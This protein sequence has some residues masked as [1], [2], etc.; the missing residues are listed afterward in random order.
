[1]FC[2]SS[3]A[4]TT[5]LSAGYEATSCRAGDRERVELL[6]PG[7]RDLR[8]CSRALVADDVVVELAR[9]E[10]E[11]PHARRA[12]TGSSMTGGNRPSASSSSREAASFRRR[13]PFGVMTTS[14]RAFGSSACRRRRWKYCADVLGVDDADVLL[15]GQLQEALEPGARMLGPVALVAVRQQQRQP[16]RLAPLREARD[17][18]LVD[19]DLRAVH[20]VAEL[21]LPE[22]ERLRR[23]DRVAVLEAERRVLGQRRVVDL[24][25]RLASARFFIGAYCSPFSASWS[26]R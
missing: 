3:C 24:E 23:A 8:R 15:R 21:R 16:R 6:E 12:S 9:A 7:D 22:H 14:G 11:P 18:E 20:E 1:M 10:D 26:T 13:S 4:Q 2:G 17:E 19:D 25:R 5:S